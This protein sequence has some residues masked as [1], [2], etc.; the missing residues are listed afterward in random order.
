MGPSGINRN[1]YPQSFSQ[2]KTFTFSNPPGLFPFV[3]K[4]YQFYNP[5]PINQLVGANMREERMKNVINQ[6]YSSSTY[7]CSKCGFR[8]Q[9]HSALKEH[10]DYHFQQSVLAIERRSGPFT[11]K[12][13]STYFNC[14]SD[15][16]IDIINHHHS[17]SAHDQQ[18]HENCL[19]FS[20][21]DNQC[22]IC[23]E[24]FKTVLKDDDEW[25]F[26]RCKKIQVNNVPIQVHVSN[27]AKII[28]E[29]V[30]K[31]NDLKEKTNE[32]TGNTSQASNKI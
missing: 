23:G 30:S 26:I 21:V 28:E 14:T 12:P 19:P 11:R 18:E 29:Q 9:T 13:F 24:E 6:L 20:S 22:F 8:F 17:S 32:N 5:P 10:L 1:G 25:Y 15:S 31:L 16:N 4:A 2:R 3:M 27:C 7:K